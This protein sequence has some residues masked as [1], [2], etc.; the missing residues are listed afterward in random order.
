MYF[1]RFWRIAWLGFSQK[2]PTYQSEG[3]PT[4]YGPFRFNELPIRGYIEHLVIGRDVEDVGGKIYIS[5]SHSDC[6]V[7]N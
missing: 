2:D 6:Q 5:L 3:I 4:F 1:D 7:E